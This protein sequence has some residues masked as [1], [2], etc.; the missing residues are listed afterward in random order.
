MKNIR[1][2]YNASKNNAQRAYTDLLV[3][4]T[5]AHQLTKSIFKELPKN[6][7]RNP[8]LEQSLKAHIGNLI[9]AS[10]TEDIEKA[11]KSLND[12]FQSHLDS[13]SNYFE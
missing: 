4:H 2:L 1:L 10:S 6:A 13:E 3:A 11:K 9:A 5:F 12:Y 8:E 7:P